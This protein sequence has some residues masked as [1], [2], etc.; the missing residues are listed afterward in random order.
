MSTNVI[1][2]LSFLSA[3]AFGAPLSTITSQHLPQ[4]PS[5]FTMPANATLAAINATAEHKGQSPSSSHDSDLSTGSLI[6]I[7]LGG[8]V[9]L[10][11]IL[12]VA[13]RLAQ[14]NRQ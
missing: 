1:F 13:H 6:G 7:V 3:I 4:L 8:L 10:L 11:V 14:R 5:N 12:W 2:I 9:G